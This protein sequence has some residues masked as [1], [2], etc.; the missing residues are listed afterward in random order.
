MET[1]QPNEI[2]HTDFLLGKPG[3]KISALDELTD[4]ELAAVLEKTDL[5]EEE[6]PEFVA[7]RRKYDAVLTAIC[8]SCKEDNIESANIHVRTLRV[9]NGTLDPRNGHN[10]IVDGKEVKGEFKATPWYNG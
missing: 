5:K 8:K 7:L 9:A 4:D 6:I 1:L 10:V 3:M 2:V